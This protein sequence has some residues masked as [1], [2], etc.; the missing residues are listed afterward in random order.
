MAALG[1]SGIFVVEAVVSLDVLRSRENGIA[2]YRVRRRVAR[3]ARD[4]FLDQHFFEYVYPVSATL[5][6][7][8]TSRNKKISAPYS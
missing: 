5:S 2:L 7:S 6:V 4:G 3:S 8:T 1:G